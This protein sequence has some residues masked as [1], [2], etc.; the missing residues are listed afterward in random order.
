M[1]TLKLTWY[2]DYWSGWGFFLHTRRG[3]ILFIT[4]GLKL[5]IHYDQY[6]EAALRK[7]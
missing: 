1:E 6:K 5:Y 2:L 7:Q 3:G 4:G